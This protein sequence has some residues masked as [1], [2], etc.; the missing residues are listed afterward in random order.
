MAVFEGTF[1]SP[2]SR[3]V[4]KS[5][6]QSQTPTAGES[7][8]SV[9]AAFDEIGM[10]RKSGWYAAVV[11]NAAGGLSM[12]LFQLL[13]PGVSPPHMTIIGAALIAFAGLCVVGLRYWTDANWAV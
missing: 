5:I 10:S 1:S 9:T 7:D 12:I 3:P 11:L 6:K 2:A 13:L 8:A 4:S